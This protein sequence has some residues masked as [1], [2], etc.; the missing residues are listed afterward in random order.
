MSQ[1]GNRNPCKSNYNR[2]YHLVCVLSAYCEANA[3]VGNFDGGW[4]LFHSDKW[5]SWYELRTVEEQ[6]KKPRHRDM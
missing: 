4:P 5:V 2:K 1:Q 6:K 3:C